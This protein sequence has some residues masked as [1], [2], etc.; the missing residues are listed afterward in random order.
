[1]PQLINLPVKKFPARTPTPIMAK[2]VK[3]IP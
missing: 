2:I 3:R 1:V